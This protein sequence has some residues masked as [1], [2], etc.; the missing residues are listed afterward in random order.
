VLELG[1]VIHG[2]YEIVRLLGQGGMGSVY[3]GVNLRIS[4]R[5][6][7]KVLHASIARERDHVARF[8]REA[9]AAA[10]IGSGHIVDVFDLGDLPGGERFMIMEFLEGESLETRLKRGPI[11]AGEAVALAVQLLEGLAAVH[12]AGIIHR[13]LKPAN[14]FLATTEAEGTF[15]KILDFGVCKMTQDGDF[16]SLTGFGD[17]LGTLSYM[18]PELLEQGSK[19]ADARGDLYAVGVLLYRTVAGRLPHVAKNLIDLRLELRSGKTPP[20]DQVAEVEPGL[21]EIVARATDWD[22]AARFQSARD[23][24]KAL[25]DWLKATSRVEHLLT[26]FLDVPPPVSRPAMPSVPPRAASSAP[27]P[28]RASSKPSVAAASVPVARELEPTVPEAPSKPNLLAVQRVTRRMPAVSAPPK[29]GVVA[30]DIPVEVDEEAF[31]S[32]ADS[33]RSAGKG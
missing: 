1:T 2:K 29:A 14:I 4:R 30:A 25:L 20:L 19:H 3:E 27:V 22:A 23:F 24:Q 31:A 21:S 6:A 11:P 12:E 17:M 15:V 7:V 26:D 18:S 16:E 13:D 5:I 9:Q 28:P 10:R 8:E 32:Q 33:E